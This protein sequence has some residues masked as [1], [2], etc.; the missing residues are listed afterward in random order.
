MLYWAW[1]LKD[2]K[3][4]I[5]NRNGYNIGR[6]GVKINRILFMLECFSEKILV[7]KFL[8]DKNKDRQL[9]NNSKFRFK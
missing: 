4:K 2:C 1:Q 9:E 3:T 7:V 8:N 6:R 5:S